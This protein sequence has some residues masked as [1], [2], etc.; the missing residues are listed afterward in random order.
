MKIGVVKSNL[1]R[2]PVQSKVGSGLNS[3]NQPY[4][5][6]SKIPAIVSGQSRRPVGRK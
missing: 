4:A 1:G 5:V 3:S 2:Q 6:T